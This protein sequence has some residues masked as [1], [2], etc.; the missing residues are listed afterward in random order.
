MHHLLL[1]RSIIII[2]LLSVLLPFSFGQGSDI[3]TLNSEKEIVITAVGDIM[4]GTAFPSGEYLPPYDN[5]YPLMESVFPLLDGS[6]ILFGN[7]EGPFSGDEKLVKR[8]RD[9]TKCYAFRMPE[10]YAAVLDSAGFNILSLANNHIMDFGSEGLN[11]TARILDSLDIKFAGPDKYPFSIFTIDSVKYGFCAFSPNKGTLNITDTILAKKVVRMLDDTC[12]I[13]IVSFHGGAEGAEHQYVTRKEELFYG[14]NRGNVYRFAHM[15]ID[16]GADVV[17][18]HGP[19]VTRA[20]EVYRDRFIAYSLGNFCTY[21]RF[22]ISGPNGYAPV[23]KVN[24]NIFGKFIKALVLPV[25]H[26]SYG[27]VKSDPNR[28][29]II[30]LQQL[31]ISDFPESVVL[32]TDDGLIKLK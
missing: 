11:N 18:G 13:V 5:P 24:T 14:E 29:A 21:R 22:N 30:R 9:T 7:L 4:L 27:H 8:C 15:V 3:D 16:N 12:D 25:Y 31:V 6:D 32:I 26:N 2:L 1:A 10:H 28:R 20:I 23:I 17:L 19:H